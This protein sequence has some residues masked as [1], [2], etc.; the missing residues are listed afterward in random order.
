MAL[1]FV[2]KK[3]TAVIPINMDANQEAAQLTIS[4][5]GGRNATT[6]ANT[7]VLTDCDPDGMATADMKL[8]QFFRISG[9]AF[10]LFWP[11][12]TEATTTPVQWAMGFSSN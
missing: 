5:I 9:V 3:Y 1:S 8:Y 2:K 4:H 11:E 10:K 6:P 7:T 12:G